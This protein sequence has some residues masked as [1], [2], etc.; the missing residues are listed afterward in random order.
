M[1]KE[2]ALAAEQERAKAAEV[3]KAKA[4]KKAQEL[5]EVRGGGRLAAGPPSHISL[6][7]VLRSP[8]STPPG[9]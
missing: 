9:G 4:E 2:A 3:Q 5:T 7:V 8:S 6:D 1:E